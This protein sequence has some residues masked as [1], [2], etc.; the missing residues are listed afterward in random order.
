MAAIE[1]RLH[2]GSDVVIWVGATIMKWRFG[3]V[4]EKTRQCGGKAFERDKRS[5]VE[6]I[7]KAIFGRRRDFSIGQ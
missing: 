4:K 6:E 1:W 3:N 2:G 7:R 5:S